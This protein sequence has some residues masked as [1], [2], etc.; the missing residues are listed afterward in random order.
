MK[1]ALAILGI[2]SV[3]ALAGCGDGTGTTPTDPA[4]PP[5]E[6]TPLPGEPGDDMD[7]DMDEDLNP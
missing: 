7:D 4:P 1:R 3:F 5:A 2:A 6:E